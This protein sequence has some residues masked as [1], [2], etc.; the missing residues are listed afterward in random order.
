MAAF[1]NRMPAGI[2]G[3]L[4]RIQQC[5]VTPEVITP[6]TGSNPTVAPQ[7]YGILTT[8]DATTQNVRTVVTGDSGALTFGFLARPFPTNSGQNGLGVSTPPASGAV[9]YMRRGFMAVLL[10]GTQAAVRG[11][12]VYIWGAAST[13]THVQGGVEA[14]SPG[15][16]GFTLTGCTFM[17]P[18]DASG[19]TE[20]AYLP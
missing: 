15:G 14:A 2:P 6:Y 16:S 10:G 4:N 1:I 12:Q 13:G 3:D 11:G 17:G 8:I 20:I 19:N 7:S 9:D 18:A 5:V